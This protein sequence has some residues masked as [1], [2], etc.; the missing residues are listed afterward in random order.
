MYCQTFISEKTWLKVCILITTDV[1]KL[2]MIKMM[3]MQSISI[4][5]NYES[6]SSLC[7][8]GDVNLYSIDMG[9]VLVTI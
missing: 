3:E 8:T 9:H 6:L 4:M 2:F 1:I 5:I 7:H